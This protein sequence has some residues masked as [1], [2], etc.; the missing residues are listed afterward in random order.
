MDQECR[1]CRRRRRRKSPLIA[2]VEG[3][4]ATK[5]QDINLERGRQ[6]LGELLGVIDGGFASG[7]EGGGVGMVKPAGEIVRGVA[8]D[9]ENAAPGS[10]SMGS[11]ARGRSGG[12]LLGGLASHASP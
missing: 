8:A 1:P 10:T 7:G 2:V 6:D 5:V 11:T 9:G 12:G 3:L 4:V